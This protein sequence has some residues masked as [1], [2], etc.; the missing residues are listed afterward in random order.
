MGQKVV[1]LN[2]PGASGQ[3]GWGELANA[4]PDGYTIGVLNSPFLQAPIQD[5]NCKFTKDSFEPIANIVTDPGCVYTSA[6]NSWNNIAD[7]IAAAKAKPSTITVGC[8]GL[9]TSE[10]RTINNIER[11]A[12][13]KFKIVPFNGN[14]EVNVALLGGHIDFAV[15]NV[16]SVISLINEKKMKFLAVNTTER[17]AMCPE[18][19]TLKEQGYDIMQF[20]M[21]TF[22]APKGIDPKI[23]KVLST[24]IEKG[25]KDPEFLKK[26]EKKHKPH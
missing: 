26:A 23:L 13:V 8:A 21:R 11:K 16:S 7:V 2:K 6:K 15:S 24:A 5:P 1:V 9:Q 22:A 3:I 25:L 20:S 14:D 10:A 12:G 19:T 4:T 18:V 17:S